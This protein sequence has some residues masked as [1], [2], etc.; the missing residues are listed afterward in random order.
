MDSKEMAALINGTV[1]EAKEIGVET[2]TPEQI[3]L[4]KTN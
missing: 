2:L 4:L 1:Q 3:S